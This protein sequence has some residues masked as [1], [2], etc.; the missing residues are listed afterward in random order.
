MSDDDGR[1]RAVSTRAACCEI[2]GARGHTNAPRGDSTSSSG[3]G[4]GFDDRFRGHLAAV[5]RVVAVLAI[6]AVAIAASSTVRASPEPPL[7]N[8]GSPTIPLPLPPSAPSS[9]D[10]SA[11]VRPPDA[12]VRSPDVTVRPPDVT[13]R[14]PDVIVR[15]PDLIVSPDVDGLGVMSIRRGTSADLDGAFEHELEGN[16]TALTPAVRYG[17]TP[18]AFVELALPVAYQR[19]SAPGESAAVALGNAMLGVGLLPANDRLVGL[20]LRVAAATSPSSGEGASAVAALA[21][22]RIAD[23][24]LYLPHTTSA[25][26]VAD[27]RWRGDAWWL[28]A[29]GGA[30]G[31][32]QPM[33]YTTVLRATLAAGMRVA[34]WL[35]VTASFVTRLAVLSRD[36]PDNFIHGVLIGAV[37]HQGHDQ[38]AVR[39]ELPV[40]SAARDDHRVVI[41]VELR[42]P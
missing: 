37:L 26:L 19:A 31:W 30:A 6:V 39:V 28:Q 17:A 41:G 3:V 24:E 13:V 21:A 36:S 35:D 9:D 8:P 23:P 12:T 27:W 25:E 10:G 2:I 11:T 34:P 15:S 4:N 22:P 7:P 14:P 42:A 29:E 16:A 40:D 5:L 33:G 32:W 1:S 18:S 20:E 38:L